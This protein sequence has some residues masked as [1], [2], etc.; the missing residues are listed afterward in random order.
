MKRIF[1]ILMSVILLCLLSI[2]TVSA[3]ESSFSVV[4][5]YYKNGRVYSFLDVNENSDAVNGKY[6]T[7]EDGFIGKTDS[8]SVN[9]TQTN[10]EANYMF[11]ID[12]STSMPQYKDQI[13]SLADSLLKSEKSLVNVTVCT[14]GE[15]FSLVKSGLTDIEKITKIV[16]DLDYTEQATDICWGL[17]DAFDFVSSHVM[18]AGEIWEIVLIT[19]GIPYLNDGGND[20]TELKTA[21]NILKE[22]INS[23][24]EVVV[25]SIC[26]ENWESY[27]YDA[28]SNG[29]GLHE[30][31]TSEFSAE[32]AG[33][34]IAKFTDSLF[35]T[36]IPYEIDL[37]IDRVD[38]NVICID[39]HETVEV[40][41]IRNFDQVG[42]E[43]LVIDP[44][45]IEG[46]TEP[47]TFGESGTT[48]PPSSPASIA[49]TESAVA[50]YDEA[51][52]DEPK[53]DGD[54]NKLIMVIAGAGLVL[55]VLIVILILLLKKKGKKNNNNNTEDNIHSIIVK[56]KVISGDCLAK[57]LELKLSD[58][59]IIGSSKNCDIPFADSSI[60]PRNTRVYLKD[61]IVYIENIGVKQ[62]TY[63]EGM[64]LYAPNR[65]RG[66]DEITIENTKFKLLF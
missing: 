43:F 14:F 46:A 5:S 62:N 49:T 47:T 64:K 63:L 59:I 66:G 30:M 40:K 28:V 18:D 2:T 9:F 61:G 52:P 4:S 34:S 37:Y 19:D 6:N 45:Y 1:A 21:S 10:C 8:E 32:Q 17:I 23:T 12:T 7:I 20:E 13:T 16:D 55:I 44:Q 31:V 33:E 36:S 35:T 22:R 26:F 25:H 58:E 42:F 51:T 29:K 60:E 57:S 48:E 39:T 54:H 50:S 56:L 24:P 11:L 27:T 3:D 41:N 65:L 38:V 53:N 15:K